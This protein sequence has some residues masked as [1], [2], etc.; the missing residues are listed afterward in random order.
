MI[1]AASHV[2]PAHILTPYSCKIIFNIILPST[3]S[4]PAHIQ[5]RE[6]ICPVLLRLK[7]KCPYK[8]GNWAPASAGYTTTHEGRLL[9]GPRTKIVAC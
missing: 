2:N 8:T 4:S 1:S 9:F 7:I 5:G 3:P 6:S